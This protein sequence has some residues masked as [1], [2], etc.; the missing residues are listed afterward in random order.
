M[1]EERSAASNGA[2]APGFAERKGLML[3]RE[4]EPFFER[5]E[6][7]RV[8]LK[9]HGMLMSCESNAVKRRIREKQIRRNSGKKKVEA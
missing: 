7:C 1:T 3:P 6:Y 9:V 8:M 5:L 4:A 2:G